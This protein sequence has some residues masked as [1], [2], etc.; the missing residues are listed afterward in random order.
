MKEEIPIKPI[1]IVEY[2]FAEAD[3]STRGSSFDVQLRV[4]ED[5]FPLSGGHFEQRD[6]A[7]R[8]ARSLART[9]KSPLRYKKYL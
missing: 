6:Q 8:K 1:I 4:G 2:G 3:R 7:R 9:L 5:V